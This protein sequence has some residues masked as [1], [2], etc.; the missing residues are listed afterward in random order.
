MIL[1]LKKSFEVLTHPNTKLKK[2]KI[3]SIV[4]HPPPHK[5]DGRVGHKFGLRRI[6]KVSPF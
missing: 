2:E 6:F 4:D 1:N 5:G 3:P